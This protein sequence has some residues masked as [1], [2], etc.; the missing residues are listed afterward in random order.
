MITALDSG[1][2]LVLIDLQEGILNFPLL[3][4]AETVLANAAKLVAAFRK[5]NLPIVIVNVDPS[6]SP[7]RDTRKDAAQR[8]TDI[9]KEWLAISKAIITQPDDIFITKKSWNAFSNPDLHEAL[10][11]RN[12]TGIVLAGISTSVGVEGTAR[13]AAE[14]GY[15]ISFATD[16]TTDTQEASFNHSV[17]AIFPR[18]GEVGLTQDILDKM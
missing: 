8:M 12:I 10:Q 1:T 14:K 17:H 18:L 3:H 11:Q 2:A 4:P 13:A 6:D 9:P 16:A 5:A 15:N 7:M